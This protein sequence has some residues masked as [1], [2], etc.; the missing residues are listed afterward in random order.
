MF[1]VFVEI[2]WLVR[3]R[4]VSIGEIRGKEEGGGGGAEGTY[5]T[6]SKVCGLGVNWCRYSESGARISNCVGIGGT[7][8]FA[9]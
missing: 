8:R 7:N 4:G 3:L 5:Q 9:S 1:L 2:I 6:A